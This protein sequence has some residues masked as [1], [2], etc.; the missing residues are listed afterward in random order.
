MDLFTYIGQRIKELRNAYGD[1]KG[2]SQEALAKLLTV[3]PN[4]IS[5]WETATYHPS[6]EDLDKLA[7]HFGISILD[8]F[9]TESTPT[10]EK[11]TAL[12]RAAKQLAPEDLDELHKY[13]EYRKARHILKAGPR[14]SPGRKRKKVK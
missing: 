7:R 3:A 13:A 6:I 10:N 1:G 2:I 5:R 12:M 9:P 11:I 8:F 4:T 14:P